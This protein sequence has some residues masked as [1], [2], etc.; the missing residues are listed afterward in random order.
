MDIYQPGT[1]PEV[2]DALP[3]LGPFSRYIR[4]NFKADAVPYDT[5]EPPFLENA[6]CVVVVPVEA[7]TFDSTEALVGRM[8]LIE[9]IARAMADGI[10]KR[11][12]FIGRYTICCYAGIPQ[13]IDPSG[14]GR[15]DE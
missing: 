10:A 9:R 6:M 4:A 5:D 1:A 8:P 14:L 12:K 11:K 7:D 13:E 3:G 15:V 2:I